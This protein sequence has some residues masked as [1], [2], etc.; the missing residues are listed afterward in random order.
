MLN[1]EGMNEPTPSSGRSSYLRWI[2]GIAV[3][4]I[5]V[6]GSFKWGMNVGA[7]GGGGRLAPIQSQETYTPEVTKGEQPT[8]V[9]YDLL[10]KAIEVLGQKYVNKPVD[11]QKILYG[12]VR[13]AV[14]AAGDPYTEFFDPSD[15]NEFKTDLN[16]KFDGIGAVVGKRD[17]NIVIIAPIEGSPAD[18]AGLRAKD[19]ILAIN[20]ESTV[21]W[22][23]DKAVSKIRGQKGTE[24]TLSI[25][26]EG[27]AKPFDVKI[28]RDTIEVKSVKWEVKT[29]AGKKIGV[30]TMT[31]FGDDTKKLF[32]QAVQDLQKEKVQGLIL[33]L[34]N[35][36]GG[37]LETSVDIASN[38]LAKN[39]VVVT[40]S[41]VEKTTPYNSLG[42]DRLSNLKTIVLINGGSASASE[43]LA[44]ALHDHKK[45]TLLG[46]KSFGKGS[47]QE[48]VDLPGGSALKV[49]IAKW[50]TPGGVHLDHDGIKPDIEVKI[51]DEDIKNEKDPQMDRALTEIVK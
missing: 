51:S 19:I 29:V 11:Q 28:I 5:A 23:V 14:A 25:F 40:E 4:V 1:T 44:G 48:L 42:Y 22:P 35:N 33:D 36:P 15:L 26:R 12:A 45:A 13:G 16:G 6:A 27:G 24:V 3:I 43:I 8:E 38:W 21:D 31:R 20:G 49:T 2:I 39:Q 50:I 9:D 10:W 32:D 30:I 7:K 41:G 17:S 34:R 46:E 18:R 37:Y 47:V